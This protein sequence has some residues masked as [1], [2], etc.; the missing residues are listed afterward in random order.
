[1]PSAIL[2][3]R[4]QQLARRIDGGG[5]ALSELRNQVAATL[6]QDPEVVQVADVRMVQRR[7]RTRL[8]REPFRTP[9]PFAL[10]GPASPNEYEFAMDYGSENGCQAESRPLS[11][12]ITGSLISLFRP[13][14]E[15]P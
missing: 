7:H 6:W 12:R 15:N 3:C 4:V 2:R 5:R 11:I 10:E 8:A 13:I 1:M 14:R 9:G